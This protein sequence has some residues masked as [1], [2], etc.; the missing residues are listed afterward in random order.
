MRLLNDS[1]CETFANASAKGTMLQNGDY[2]PD[3]RA[4]GMSDPR[5]INASLIRRIGKT[6]E[7]KGLPVCPVA[8][9]GL[10]AARARPAR[11][12]DAATRGQNVARMR[13]GSGPSAA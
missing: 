13:P 8:R 12:H 10:L 9:S 11:G 7:Y 4:T 2:M 6:I 1:R 5:A 3:S